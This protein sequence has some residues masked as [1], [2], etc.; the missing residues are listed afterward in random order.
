MDYS[1]AQQLMSMY[2]RMGKIINEA[3]SLFA[4]SL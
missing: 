2:E 1:T 3:D 4:R